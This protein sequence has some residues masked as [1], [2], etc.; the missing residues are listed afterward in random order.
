MLKLE[1]HESPIGK[2]EEPKGAT[3]KQYYTAEEAMLF[4]EPRIRDMF[5]ESKHLLF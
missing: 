2:M 4:L 5:T 1:K 3:K